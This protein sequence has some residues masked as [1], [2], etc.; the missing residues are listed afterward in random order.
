MDSPRPAGEVTGT[1][2]P[3]GTTVPVDS[4]IE[5]Q[6]P[7]R[8]TSGEAGCRVVSAPADPGA[9]HGGILAWWGY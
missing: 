6:R 1:N 4:V 8:L 7:V 2:P 3:A 5:L 9:V